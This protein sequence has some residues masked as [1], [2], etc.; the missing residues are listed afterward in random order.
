MSNPPRP[1]DLIRRID[2]EAAA[3]LVRQDRGFTAAEQ[4]EYFQWLAADPRHGEWLA[5]H[6]RTWREFNLL[7]EWKPEHS[8]E[9]NPDLLA[10]APRRRVPVVRRAWFGALAV[11]AGLAVAFFW[12]RPP[13]PVAA[14]PS[15]ILA[16]APAQGYERRVLDDGS[17][18]ELNRGARI[19]VTY[20]ATERRV[21]LDQGEA[22][23][24]V[25]KNPARP[26]VVRAGGVD[27]RAVGTAFNVRL[28]ERQV[29]VLVTEGRVRVDDA[30]KG[31]SLLAAP[32]A[33][34][35][36]VL[37]AGHAVT[38]D[39]VPAAVAAIVPVSAEEIGRRLAWRPEL[40]E[41]DS[42]PLAQV[43]A[44][45]NRHNGVRLEIADAELDAL[46]IVASFRSDNVDGFVRLLESTAGVTAERAGDTIR[47]HQAR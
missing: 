36:P 44:A 33:G 5:R 46:P 40:L 3:W 30:L 10:P 23:F 45:F 32:A 21:R 24:T 35:A 8:A 22:G 12:T 34:E 6:R 25:A 9:P 17:V 20:T 41:F 2:R 38:I 19:E 42:A 37:E 4:D 14:P 27:V 11:A 43:V 18:V 29:H 31:A 7:A 47:L 16:Q 15:A 1:P 26:F 28:D 39:V 13:A